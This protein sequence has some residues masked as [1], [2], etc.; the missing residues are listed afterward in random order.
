MIC[1]KIWLRYSRER[2]YSISSIL[3]RPWSFNFSRALPPR[4]TSARRSSTAPR[5]SSRRPTQ[6]CLY[7]R[8]RF[9]STGVSSSFRPFPRQLVVASKKDLRETSNN[10][11]CRKPLHSSTSVLLWNLPIWD[12][13]RS[14]G[15]E[16]TAWGAKAEKLGIDLDNLTGDIVVASGLIKDT[17][18]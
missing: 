9:T 6:L 13:P 12:I 17:I 8:K 11:Q 18:E 5:T 1:C 16:K 3:I 2:A 15:G 4:S 10:W 7:L 14:L